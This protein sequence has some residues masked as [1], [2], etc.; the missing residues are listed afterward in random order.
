MVFLRIIGVVLGLFGM[1]LLLLGI[2]AGNDA[3]R[4]VPLNYAVFAILGGL[5]LAMAADA[6]QKMALKQKEQKEKKEKKPEQG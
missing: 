4:N 6:G 2:V 1:V 3:V 5:L